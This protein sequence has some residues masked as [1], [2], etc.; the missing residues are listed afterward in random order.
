MW[1]SRS[2]RIA[3]RGEGLQKSAPVPPAQ[4]TRLLSLARLQEAVATAEA[5]QCTDLP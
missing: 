3:L 5:G 1:L 4:I 2:W